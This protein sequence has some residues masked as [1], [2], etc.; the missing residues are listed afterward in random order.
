MA[1]TFYAENIQALTSIAKEIITRTLPHK[2]F[3]FFGEMGVGKTTLI[4][5]LS[6]HL[7]VQDVVSSPTFSIVN[8]YVTQENGKIFHFD[9]YRI[10]NEAE[11]Y[12]IGYEEYFF[13]SNYCFIEWSEK[14]PN[15]LEKNMI[16]IHMRMKGNERIIEVK[17]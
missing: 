8:E 12:D 13:S 4:K 9:F 10:E 14:I 3:A 16:Q 17:I 7:G 15:L 6:L 5:A 1:I 2:K 11:A